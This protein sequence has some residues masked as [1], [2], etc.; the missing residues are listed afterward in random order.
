MSEYHIKLMHTV[1]LDRDT[2]DSLAHRIK[3]LKNVVMI[4][5]LNKFILHTS[6]IFFTIDLK[7]HQVKSQNRYNCL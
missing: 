5:F 1:T 4:S 6:N 3:S 2:V 7:A